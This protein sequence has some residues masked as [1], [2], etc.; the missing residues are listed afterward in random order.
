MKTVRANPA[1]AR[2]AASHVGICLVALSGPNKYRR[3]R[4][5]NTGGANNLIQDA[6]SLSLRKRRVS[7]TARL[8]HRPTKDVW[9]ESED[10]VA[11]LIKTPDC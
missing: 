7:V 3:T 6:E 9:L 8:K 4:N 1:D 11:I 10:G 2:T 5:V